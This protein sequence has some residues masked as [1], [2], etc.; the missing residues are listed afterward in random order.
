MQTSSSY[1]QYKDTM[2]KLLTVVKKLRLLE[3]NLSNAASADNADELN[4]LV[5]D[6]QPLLLEFRG[7]DRVREK[8]EASL[9]IRGHSFREVLSSFTP[10]QQ[11]ELSPVFEELTRELKLYENA[12]DSADR[13]MQVRLKDV[14][15]KISGMPLPERPIAFHDQLV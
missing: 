12:K 9:G 7:Q 14:T 2:T 13:I 4:R 3:E 6:A 10:E 15:D 5:K 8:A 1:N 11:K